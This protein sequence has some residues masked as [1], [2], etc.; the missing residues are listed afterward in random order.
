MRLFRAGPT[1]ASRGAVPGTAPSGEG[2]GRRGGSPEV[3]RRAARGDA[4]RA[5]GRGGGQ[6]RSARPGVAPVWAAALALAL[7][8]VAAAA[9]EID[10]TNV[11]FEGRLY[12]LWRLT[13]DVEDPG[14]EFL[15]NTAR[16]QATWEPAGWIEMVLELEAEE[17][18]QAGSAR[19]LLRDAYVELSPFRW[20]RVTAGQFKRSFSRIERTPRRNLRT[21]DRGLANR[22]IVERLGYGGRDLGVALTG[23]LWDAARLDYAVGVFNGPGEG[24]LESGGDG[25]KDLSARLEARPVDWFSFGL[26]VSLDTLETAD[27]PRLVEP[28]V[29]ERNPSFVDD[30]GWLAGSWWMA[31][32]DVMFR[33]A[34]LRLLV[35]ASLGENWW[36]EGAP[37]TS[38][39]TFEASYEFALSDEWDVGLEP[40]FRGE[41]VLPRIAERAQRKWRATAGVNLLLGRYVRVM[42][43]GQFTRV[44]G[45]EPNLERTPGGLAPDEWPGGWESVN[46]LLVQLAVD[47]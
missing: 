42:V 32:A 20:L 11:D 30:F 8:Q 18:L 31:E 36:Y 14:N 7:P 15:L 29:L 44:E 1:L 34:D 13:D 5:G 6:E 46:C 4:L 3:R 9:G 38:A 45:E 35:E 17:L 27:L 2:P 28:E 40:V 39:V 33:P 23:R 47:V 19:G 12:A 22:W 25:L 26:S 41:L 16:L 10:W 21:I 43:E 37:L 24:L